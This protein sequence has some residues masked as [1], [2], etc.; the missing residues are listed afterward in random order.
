[1][2]ATDANSQFERNDSAVS[3]R[4][5]ERRPRFHGLSTNIG[6]RIS[7]TAPIAMTA[8]MIVALAR[9]SRVVTDASLSG[10]VERLDATATDKFLTS[11]SGSR[12]QFLLWRPDMAKRPV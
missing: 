4:L 11:A 9:N 10:I 8:R 3:P 12:D 5:A 2:P 7:S 1:M 6:T